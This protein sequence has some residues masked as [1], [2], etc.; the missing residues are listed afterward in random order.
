MNSEKFNPQFPLYFVAGV[1]GEMGT[2]PFATGEPPVVI[3]AL[4]VFETANDARIFAA[5]HETSDGRKRAHLRTI[6]SRSAL[7]ELLTEMLASESNPV[8]HL[9]LDPVDVQPGQAYR[10]WTLEAAIQDLGESQP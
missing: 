10:M 1:S 8:K 5:E 2:I 4:P 3:P 7:S 9:I 6:P